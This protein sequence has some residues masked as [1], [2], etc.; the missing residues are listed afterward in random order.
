MP[1]RA[2]A[3]ELEG[4]GI[5]DLPYQVKQDGKATKKGCKYKIYFGRGLRESIRFPPGRELTHENTIIA[6]RRHASNSGQR[7]NLSTP[8]TAGP[9]AP[10]AGTAAAAADTAA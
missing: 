4:T 5:D 10:A 7:P 8:D 9:T 1:K 2:R 6:L 3:P